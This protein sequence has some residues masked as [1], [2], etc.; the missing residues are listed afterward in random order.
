MITNGDVFPNLNP[1]FDKKS[2]MYLEGKMRGVQI[3][4]IGF[5][6]VGS[7]VVKVLEQNGSLIYTK[8]F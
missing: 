3:G 7:G 6:T 4:L 1:L 5:G 2:S 8:G